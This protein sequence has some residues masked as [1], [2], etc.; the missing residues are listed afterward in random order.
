MSLLGSFLRLQF[1]DSPVLGCGVPSDRNATRRTRDPSPIVP[2][3]VLMPL[4]LSLSAASISTPWSTNSTAAFCNCEKA[5]N[6]SMVGVPS[7]GTV[8]FN[9]LTRPWGLSAGEQPE[10]FFV[11]QAFKVA[12]LTHG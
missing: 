2:S 11:V 4:I 8:L 5:S 3:V 7:G 9:W 6:V 12:G 1:T 10:G